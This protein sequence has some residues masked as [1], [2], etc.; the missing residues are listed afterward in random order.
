MQKT[1]DV[2]IIGGGISGLSIAFNLAQAGVK[3]IVVLEKNFLGNGATGRCGAG[4]RMQW[5][6]ELNCLLSKYSCEFFEQ[7][8]ELFHNNIDIEFEQGGYLIGAG[9]DEEVE[10]F[11]RNVKL[12]NDLGIES[13]FLSPEEAGE[14]MP[15]LDITKIKAATFCHRDGH[16]NPFRT[17]EAYSEAARSLGVSIYEYTEVQ[18]ILLD[19]DKLKGV[20]TDK[21]DISAPLVVN[22]AGGYSKLIA[23]MA[24]VDLP[25]YSQRHQIMVTEPVEAMQDPM[26]MGF[27][28]NIYIQQVPHGSFIMGRSDDSE[29]TDLRLTSSWQFLEKMSETCTTLMPRLGQLKV[30]RQWAGL[31]NMT[32]DAQPIYD[33]APELPGFYHAAGF[34]GHGFMLAPVTGHV[35]SRKIMGEKADIDVSC[36][37]VSRFKDGGLLPTES[38]VV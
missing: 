11:K 24:G 16:L 27:S 23:D 8:Q 30:V 14:I 22:A 20:R 26:F 6:T 21:G 13:V 33:E 9:T 36:L 28:L 3:N 19:G 29:P 32:A 4:I 25:V 38:S 12:Q 7:A 35:M 18:D 37:N 2:A 31:Y 10:Q 15:H 1:A 34:S 17:T 5:G